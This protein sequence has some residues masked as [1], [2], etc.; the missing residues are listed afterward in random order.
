VKPKKRKRVV[1]VPNEEFV[2]M[3]G[4]LEVRRLMPGYM[5][6]EGDGDGEI[7]SEIGNIEDGENEYRKRDRNESES[8]RSD[9]N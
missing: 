5:R 1:L 7:E 6:L 4:V 9:D 8:N 2:R 3:A